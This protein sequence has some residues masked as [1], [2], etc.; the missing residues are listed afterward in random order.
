MKLKELKKGDF[1]TRK[2]IEYPKDNQVWIRG[3]Y[4]RTSKTYSCINFND[5]NREIFLK[6]TTPVYTNFI[7]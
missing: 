5:I 2:E 3:H 4:D 6:G 1:F 7:F